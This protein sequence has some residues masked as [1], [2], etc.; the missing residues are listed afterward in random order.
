METDWIDFSATAVIPDIVL[1][2]IQLH[3][4]AG[5]AVDRQRR[6]VAEATVFQTGSGPKRTEA[7]T[8]SDGKFHIEGIMDE[9]AFV[10]VR[11][12]GFRFSGR[13]AQ[14]SADNLELV[15]AR[16]D[17]PTDR[18]LHALP[19]LLTRAERLVMAKRV[20]A[21]VVKQALANDDEN[22]RG[23][24]LMVLAKVEP[25]RVLQSLEEKPIKEPFA[26]GFIRRAVARELFKE[27]PDEART[28]AE[29]IAEPFF[30]SETYLDFCDALPAGEKQRK[31][32]LVGQALLQLQGITT[33]WMRVMS[34]AEIAKRLLDLGQQDRAAKLLRD[35]QTAAK[36]L[37]TV[38]LDGYARGSFA[39]RLSAV[40]LP[41]ALELIK[42]LSIDQG[43]SCR[44]HGNIAHIVA[45]TNPAEAERIL[46]L[47]RNNSNET[48]SDQYASRV[49]Y[50]MAPVD[51]ERAK[52]IAA[53]V[54]D[55]YQKAQAHAVMA[56]ALAKAQPTVARELLSQAFDVLEES[57]K[58]GKDH[59][60]GQHDPSTVAAAFL[61]VVEQIDPQ[62]VDEFLWRAIALR[63]N[64]LNRNQQNNPSPLDG[65]SQA[66]SDMR[67]A[68]VLARYDRTL[69][70]ALFA[71]FWKRIPGALS[72]RGDTGGIVTAAAVLDPKQAVAIIEGL[73]D[74]D[75][76]TNAAR[77]L[78]KFLALDDDKCWNYI[79]REVLVLWVV[80]EE[81]FGADE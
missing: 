43:D 17:E 5:R 14:G 30:R 74:G 20:L 8:D 2:R 24:L 58:D 70:D 50:R 73:P 54:T 21:P 67:L 49:C 60:D 72:G 37:A 32:E 52:R 27:S 18:P 23:D 9:N 80:D 47:M 53:G 55:P 62:L 64:G 61:P 56:Q 77:R 33:P 38:D 71:S 51:L 16:A 28:V 45:G 57:I 3:A 81:D 6:P 41:A 48:G 44:H 36:A 11:K 22:A 15:L 7:A 10:F 1:H 25:E 29:S 12:P 76:K 66:S 65:G 19:L 46:G 59:F 79:Q 34:H 42:D 40:D 68:M 35:G 26:Q 63:Q 69:A 75:A 78:A 31:L 13:M 4:V 39:E